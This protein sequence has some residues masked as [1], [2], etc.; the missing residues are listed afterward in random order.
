MHKV[1]VEELESGMILARDVEDQGGYRILGAGSKLS[2]SQIALLESWSV[3]DVWIDDD[4]PEEEEPAQEADGLEEARERLR[5]RFEGRLVNEYME[6]LYEQAEER[7]AVPRF[8][9]NRV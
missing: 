2:E 5:A 3:I 7:L 1:K 4:T 6:R 9:K 8:W